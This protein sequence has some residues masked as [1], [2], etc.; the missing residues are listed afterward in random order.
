MGSELVVPLGVYVSVLDVGVP[1]I[2][3]VPLEVTFIVLVSIEVTVEVQLCVPVALDVGDSLHEYVMLEVDTLDKFVN[4]NVLLANVLEL[5][6]LLIVKA[7]VVVTAGSGVADK[8][9]VDSTVSVGLDALVGTSAEVDP[10]IALEMLESVA[11][12]ETDT[13]SGPWGSAMVATRRPKSMRSGW[14]FILVE[15]YRLISEC[16]YISFVVID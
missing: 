5:E 8:E 13:E 11:V 16:E 10:T 3:Y 6:L 9:F 1:L 12:E 7:W 14:D 4:G 15:F 2:V